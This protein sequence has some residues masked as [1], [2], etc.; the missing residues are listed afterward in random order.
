MGKRKMRK[1]AKKNIVIFSVIFIFLA[2]VVSSYI[3]LNYYYVKFDNISVKD[4]AYQKGKVNITFNDLN[5]KVSCAVVKTGTKVDVN[6]Q[7]IWNKVVENKCSTKIKKGNSYEIYLKYENELIDF[8]Y[9][10]KVLDVELN[11]EKCYLALKGSCEVKYE[12][13]SIL[14]ADVSLKASNSNVTVKNNKITGVKEGKTTIS[15]EG[16]DSKEKV[17]VVVTDLILKRPKKYNYNRSYLTCNVFNYEE[18][19]LLDEILEHRINEKGYKTRAGVVEAARFLTLEFPYRISYFS[20]NG[21]LASANKVDGEGRYYHKGL[22][23]TDSKFDTIEYPA[24]GPNP[25]G[26]MIYSNPSKGMRRNG[27]DCSGFTTWVIFNGGFDPGDMGAHGGGDKSNDLNSIGE[28]RIVTKE[29]SLSDEIKAGDF[30]GEVTVSEGHS[31]I[32]IGVDKENFYVAES[33]WIQPLGVNVNTYKRSEF[34]KYFETVNLMDSYY[35]E[36]GDYTA[37]WY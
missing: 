36:D 19:K 25:W 12:V 20:E 21:R 34:H 32:V 6:D 28:E 8:K 27:L 35:K 15:I 9:D 11:K 18:E 23:L 30:L 1:K 37:M 22:Y 2:Y 5:D 24:N 7:K 13:T 29:L 4:I 10:G 31:A 33:L 14:D 17:D 26:C 16:F 3:Y